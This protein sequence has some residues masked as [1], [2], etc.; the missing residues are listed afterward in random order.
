[1][2]DPDD[3]ENPFPHPIE[4]GGNAVGWIEHEIDA[5]LQA[6]AD[7]RDKALAAG[8]PNPRRGRGRR[9]QADCRQLNPTKLDSMSRNSMQKVYRLL[10]EAREEEI[11]PWEWIVDETPGLERVPT[12]DDPEDYAR[13]VAQS[14]RRDFWN[15]QPHRVVVWSEKGTVRGV[16]K[17]VLDD[18]A[19]G[20]NPVHGYDSATDVHNFCIDNDGRPLI[21][22]YI[23][24]YDPSGLNMS[25]VDLPK[26]IE[27]Y[28]GYHIRLRRIA[29]LREQT[30]GLISFPATDKVEDSRYEWFVRNYGGECWELDA[31]DPRNLRAL[32]EAEIKKLIEPEAWARCKAINKAEHESLRTVL[33]AWNG[34]G[35]KP[36]LPEEWDY[37]WPG[38]IEQS[39]QRA[40]QETAGAARWPRR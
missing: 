37:D 34:C 39:K 25:E 38:A 40:N 27:K 32:V 35:G 20:F 5:Y 31:M 9:K 33:D 17:P 15:Q 14:Y 6:K 26:R 7:A 2:N 11:I 8:I 10:K 28:Q 16:L 23:G 21:I 1:M 36:A 4:L 29:L 13:A 12:W 24:D 18:Y 22:L 19:V 30:R 3:P